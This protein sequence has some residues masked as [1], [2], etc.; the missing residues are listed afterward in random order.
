MRN[1]CTAEIVRPARPGG[2]LSH[3]ADGRLVFGAFGTANQKDESTGGVPMA[4]I[5]NR[6]PKLVPLLVH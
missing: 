3:P 1:K 4:D 5:G 2:T 6:L